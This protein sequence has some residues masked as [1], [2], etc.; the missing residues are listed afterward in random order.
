MMQKP[1]IKNTLSKLILASLLGLGQTYA[2]QLP[3]ES[4]LT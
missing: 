2:I 1:K 3:K 4:V